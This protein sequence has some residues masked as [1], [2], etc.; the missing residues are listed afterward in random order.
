MRIRSNRAWL[1]AGAALAA[2]GG[3]IV[4][5]GRRPKIDAD[6]RILL[7]GDSLAQGLAPQ[8]RA[9]AE[10]EGLPFVALGVQG[11]LISDWAGLV[12]TDS[13]AALAATL[14]SFRP[15]LILVSLGTNDEYA[16]ASYAASEADD[17]EAL[18]ALVEE[19]GEVVWLGP[20]ELPH[21]ESNGATAM[22]R[23]TGVAYFPSDR[24]E[25]PRGGDNLHPTVAG[26]GSWAG[27]LWSWLT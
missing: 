15:T 10:D 17:L 9:M 7:V 24:L 1:L 23:Q 20:P 16:S 12:P 13:S 11:S 5:L 25:I 14:E 4:F 2:V 8:L 3:A 22:I 26:Y 18:L 19:Y 6:S 27:M 21:E